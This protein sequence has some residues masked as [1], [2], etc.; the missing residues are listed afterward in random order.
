LLDITS[1]RLVSE[2]AAGPRV[3]ADEREIVVVD[4]ECRPPILDLSKRP[5]LADERVGGH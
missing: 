3:L 5:E 2:R 1:E 4:C